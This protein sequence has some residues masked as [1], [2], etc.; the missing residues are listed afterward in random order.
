MAPA[1]CGVTV[2]LMD[3]EGERFS[4]LSN[5][6]AEGMRTVLYGR[7]FRNSA[8]ERRRFC[9]SRRAEELA[10]RERSLRVG[11]RNGGPGAA[12]NASL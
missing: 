2:P 5:D 11:R 8:V 3:L 9:E 12:R 1:S 6:D 10:G 4:F 7:A